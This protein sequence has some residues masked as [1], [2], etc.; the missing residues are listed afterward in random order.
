MCLFLA[1]LN[2]A[3]QIWS[4]NRTILNFEVGKFEIRNFPKIEEKIKKF[5]KI[6]FFVYRI[7]YTTRTGSGILR[8]RIY[9]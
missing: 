6:D 5:G 7:F 3:P 2:L 9:G 8:M 4:K 1:A